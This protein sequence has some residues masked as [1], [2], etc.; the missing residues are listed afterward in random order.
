MRAYLWVD[1]GRGLPSN[2]QSASFGDSITSP[3]GRP[4]GDVRSGSHDLN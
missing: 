4:S 1:E 3:V 2:C